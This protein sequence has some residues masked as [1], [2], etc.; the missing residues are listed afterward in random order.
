MNPKLLMFK[1]E[2][3]IFVSC[4]TLADIRPSLQ[5]GFQIGRTWLEWKKGEVLDEQFIIEN[6]SDVRWDEKRV[7]ANIIT[8]FSADAEELAAKKFADHCQTL[9]I[10]FEAANIAS[11][12]IWGKVDVISNAARKMQQIERQL[13]AEEAKSEGKASSDYQP[14][15]YPEP[16]HRGCGFS[17]EGW[18]HFRD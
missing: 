5:S 18:G 16:S 13:E 4:K 9:E 14:P 10:S 12:E 3:L 8:K 11:K 15:Y 6:Y 17:S 1:E 2:G 7:P